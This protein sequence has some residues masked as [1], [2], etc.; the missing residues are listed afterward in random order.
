MILAGAVRGSNAHAIMAAYE[1]QADFVEGFGDNLV[2]TGPTQTN[3]DNFRAILIN[4]A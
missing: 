1:A 4:P 2:T 3:E